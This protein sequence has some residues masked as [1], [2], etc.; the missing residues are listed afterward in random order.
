[1]ERILKGYGTKVG[2]TAIPLDLNNKHDR[3]IAVNEFIAHMAE[4]RESTPLW[5]KIVGILRAALRRIAPDLK[6]T[7]ADILH[8]IDRARTYSGVAPK[9]MTGGKYFKKNIETGHGVVDDILRQIEAM[10]PPSMDAPPK[11]I[12]PWLRDHA[13]A[14]AATITSYMPDS[15]P[16]GHFLERILKNPLWYEHPVLKELF[17]VMAHARQETYHEL[18]NDFNDAGDGRTVADEIARLRK[19]D[20]KGYQDLSKI[21][22]LADTEWV[23][24]REYSFEDQHQGNEG[25][26]GREAGCTA[27][28]GLPLTRCWMRGRHP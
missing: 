25:V 12:R 8:L 16:H 24:D 26:R 10:A 21:L 18:F 5:T 4:T 19:T 20:R 3:R 11:E 15:L 7:D 22:V 23:R 27:L 6:W 1:M 13:K 17:N 9:A 2:N 14:A 28:S